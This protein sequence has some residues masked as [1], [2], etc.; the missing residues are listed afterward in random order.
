[1]KRAT[2]ARTISRAGARGRFRS[3]DSVGGRPC[4]GVIPN[5]AVRLLEW[6]DPGRRWKPRPWRSLRPGSDPIDNGSDRL[7]E[8]HQLCRPGSHSPTPDSGQV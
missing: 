4:V 5:Q 6:S 3:P 2:G 8:W 7:S 1:M